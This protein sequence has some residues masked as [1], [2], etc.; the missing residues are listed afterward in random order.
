MFDRSLICY[1]DKN[2][3]IQT[4]SVLFFFR[5]VLSFWFCICFENNL[6]HFCVL[7]RMCAFFGV[8][9]HLFCLLLN[10]LCYFMLFS[11]AQSF[12]TLVCK[13]T[14]GTLVYFW[15]VWII[16]VYTIVCSVSHFLHFFTIA[17]K[18]S[19]S[20][21]QNL[22]LCISPCFTYICNLIEVLT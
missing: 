14:I 16:C 9:L 21:S 2:L 19:F 20:L 11:Q 12:A 18:P 4:P 22:H 6:A 3:T 13:C 8:I 7:L 1:T 10:A 17:P 5:A 15:C